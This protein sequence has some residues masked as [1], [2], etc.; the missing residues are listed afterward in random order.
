MGLN[1]RHNLHRGDHKTSGFWRIYP[2]SILFI[3]HTLLVA[4]INSSYM[5]RFVSTEGVGA[6]Y[7]IGSAISVL[8]FLFFSHALKIVGNLKLS[9]ILA[10]IDALSLLVLGMTE[11]RATAITAFVVFQVVTPLLYLNIDI[12]SETMIGKQES[13]TGTKR[14][15]ALGLMSVA[16]VIAPLLMSYIVDG[17]T[18][19]NPVYYVAA[20]IAGAFIVYLVLAF[21]DF[22][23]PKY[24]I[25]RV[26]TSLRSI[27][28]RSDI[29]NVMFAHFLLQTFFT[30][31][32]IYFPL[33]MFTELGFH[34]D[35]IGYI[36]AVGL[37]AYVVIEWPV[38]YVADKW[39]GEKELMALGFFILSISTSWI[40]FMTTLEVL[41]WMVLL[42]M[43]R[44]GAALV[45]S[46]T[47]IYFFKHSNGDD[48]DTISFFRLL[49]PLSAVFGAL[50]GAAALLYLPFNLIFVVLGLLMVPG[51]FF[52]I[53]LRDTK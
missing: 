45:E 8:A 14:G 1:R 23:D 5:E 10:I 15:L 40:S 26:R 17:S 2:L 7:T 3:F 31:T 46:T 34:W 9:L 13:S 42:F 35:Q 36:I 25:F 50:L 24:D 48:A 49:R 52:T 22:K 38:G 21:A 16:A 47:E 53:N 11:H 51:I 39:L 4:Y 18:N 37:L 19:L 41:P 44:V 27:W 6:L 43:T 29:R 20:A 30:W 12:F 33:Y 32:V 28:L